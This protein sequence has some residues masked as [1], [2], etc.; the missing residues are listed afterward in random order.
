MAETADASV[1]VE[2]DGRDGVGLVRAEAVSSS[3]RIV[4][5]R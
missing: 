1:S 5:V 3:G 2:W 4:V